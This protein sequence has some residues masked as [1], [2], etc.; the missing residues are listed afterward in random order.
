[1]RAVSPP[2][3]AARLRDGRA[4]G[5][6]GV[7]VIELLIV[8][9]IGAMV[10]VPVFGLLTFTI[11]RHEPVRTMNDQA[12]QL[13]LF[14]SYLARDWASARLIKANSSWPYLEC[15]GA[16]WGV[17]ETKIAMLTTDYKR[18]LYKEVQ[19][20]SHVDIVRLECAHQSSYP[21]SDPQWITNWGYASAPTVN[22]RIVQDVDELLVPSTCNDWDT[23]DPCDMNVT[24]RTVDGQVSTLRLRQETG[25]QS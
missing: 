21:Q 1:M 23:A 9:V 4:R 24:V 19:D 8:V 10:L 11:R 18:I 20:G 2:R 12:S 6:S 7:T 13:R 25:R 14:R 5:Q 22:R 17:G 3:G 16:M 15:N